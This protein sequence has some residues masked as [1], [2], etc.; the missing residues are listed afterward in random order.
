MSKKNKLFIILGTLVV[1]LLI[2][3]III[4][5]GFGR[6]AKKDDRVQFVIEPGMGKLKIIDEL[7]KEKIIKSKYSALIYLT[8][9]PKM[10]LQAGNYLINRHNTSL[11]ILKKI[12]KGE[13]N[14]SDKLVLL[15]FSEGLR[16]TDYAR[17]ISEKFEYEY[18]DVIKVFK[19]KSFAQSLIHKLDFLKEDILDPKIYYPLEGYLYPETYEFYKNAP[20]EDIIEK[21]VRETGKRIS[22]ISNHFDDS[23]YSLHQILTMASIVEREAKTANDRARVAQVIYK[24]LDI[25]MTLGMDVTTYYAHQKSFKE[26]LTKKELNSKN[27]YNTRNSEMFGLPIG[28]ICNPS[29]NSI[30]AVLNPADT[31]YIY[32]FADLKTGDVSFFE[33]EKDFINHKNEQ[34]RLYRN[35]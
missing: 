16:V 26:E 12:S 14:Y 19:D 11:E 25:N 4:F 23:N 27:P 21:I 29:V 22:K 31:N 34:N 10:Q 30:T 7:K 2:N 18:D 13:I 24:R 9:N 33:K 17:I 32:F 6:V 5:I 28:P 8:L 20:I 15:T 1:I 35:S 3:L